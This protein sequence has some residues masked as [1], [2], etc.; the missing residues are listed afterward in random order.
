MEKKKNVSITLRLTREDAEKFKLNAIK[1]K[2]SQSEYLVQLMS[3]VGNS[4]KNMGE[5]SGGDI[6]II[7]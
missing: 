2:V 4:Q 6:H 7:L 5:Q 1:N 3:S